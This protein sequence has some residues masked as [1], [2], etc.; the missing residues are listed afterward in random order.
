[1]HAT[2]ENSPRNLAGVLAL[3]EKGLGLAVDEAEGLTKR[4]SWSLVSILDHYF[5]TSSPAAG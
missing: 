3:Q 5:E 1:V 2:E 4:I